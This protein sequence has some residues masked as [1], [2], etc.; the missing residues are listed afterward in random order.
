MPACPA[1]NRPSGLHPGVI[2]DPTDALAS[3][4]P[5]SHQMK[6]QLQCGRG[7]IR[8]YAAFD[9]NAQFVRAKT[10]NFSLSEPLASITCICLPLRS[11]ADGLHCMLPSSCQKAAPW[12]AEGETR[13]VSGGNSRLEQE[14]HRSSET[15]SVL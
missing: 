10:P 4:M 9:D 7:R 15:V 1:R 8:S 3:Q 6:L 11:R 13:W 5:G 2:L 12:P 14:P